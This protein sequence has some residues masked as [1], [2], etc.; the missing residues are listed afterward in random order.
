MMHEERPG[1]KLAA[2]GGDNSQPCGA[3]CGLGWLARLFPGAVHVH[4]IAVGREDM[5]PSSPVPSAVRVDDAIH[6]MTPGV[7]PHD[8]L[9]GTNPVP[10]DAKLASMTL[11][12][13]KREP[14]R[15]RVAQ[16]EIASDLTSLSLRHYRL[17]IDNFECAATVKQEVRVA[18]CLGSCLHALTTWLCRHL[19]FVA[20]SL[21][22]TPAWA[23][24]RM[25]S[26]C[27][28]PDNDCAS[29]RG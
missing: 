10:Y 3:C 11:E 4:E 22:L 15:L 28:L 17:H 27:A 7:Q 29:G 21:P 9:Q 14:W 18:S 20:A 25:P 1:E 23:R 5:E 19:A 26:W 8:Q 13:L 6:M 16:E 12:R 24:L 2:A